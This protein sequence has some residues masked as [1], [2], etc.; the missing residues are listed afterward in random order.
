MN[1]GSPF[2][3]VI[4][5]RRITMRFGEWILANG[6]SLQ[7]SLF[8]SLLVLLAVAERLLPRRPGPMHRAVRWRANFIL[9]FLNFVAL[10]VLPLSFITAAFWA[11][12]H[13]WGLLNVIRLP[14]VV[15]VILNL[16]MRGFISFFTHY[17]MHM[18]PLFWRIHRVHHLDTELDVTTT[19]RFHPLE[20][21]VGLIPGV[22]LV[23]LFGLSP[24]L[25]MFYELLDVA[26]TLW[27]HSNL[28]I[29][30]SIE[31][32]IRYVFVTPDLHRIHHS[33]REPETNSNYGAVFPVWDLIFGT[34]NPTPR[35]G[36][37]HMLLGLEEI[38]GD[39]AHRSIWLLGSVLEDRLTA[40]SRNSLTHQ[41]FG[42]RKKMSS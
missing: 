17:L 22:P 13:G 25:L 1:S 9:T 19:V 33:T 20:F 28:R 38:R 12:A 6:E 16:M 15:A 4:Q 26:V 31:R 40:Q 37:E 18:V 7:V 24:W 14:L 5:E 10:S 30:G 32:V 41:A 29:Q 39:D 27:T 42:K 8:F 3:T 2:R 23:V 21:V 11:E 34:F 36:H 35:D